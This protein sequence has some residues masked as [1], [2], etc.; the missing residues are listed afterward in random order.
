MAVR[1]RVA[2]IYYDAYFDFPSLKKTVPAFVIPGQ[3]PPSTTEPT[4]FELL[5]AARNNPNGNAKG[6]PPVHFDKENFL[7]VFE[8]RATQLSIVSLGITHLNDIKPSLGNKVRPK[9]VYQMTEFVFAGGV[10]AWQLYVYRDGISITQLPNPKSKSV[11]T[12]FSPVKGDGKGFKSFDQTILHDNDEVIFRQVAIL[13]GPLPL[14][15][16][17]ETPETTK[18]LAKPVKSGK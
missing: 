17:A 5:E 8:R 16:D 14:S 3:H 13:R 15:E 18:A 10:V 2:G 1:L 6:A 9:G 11:T 4:V 12:G 7:Y